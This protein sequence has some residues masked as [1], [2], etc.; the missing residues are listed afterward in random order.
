M[1]LEAVDYWLVGLT[2][3]GGG[4]WADV[5]VGFDWSWCSVCLPAVSVRT[6]DD[7]L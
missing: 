3:R 5:Y 4:K 7:K 6:L 1:A 2:G